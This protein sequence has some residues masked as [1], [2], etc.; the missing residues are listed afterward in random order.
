LKSKWKKNLRHFNKTHSGQ[1]M[2]KAQF[3]IPF[4]KSWREAICP[5][6]IIAGWRKS[7]LWPVNKNRISKDVFAPAELF[8]KC[9][10]SNVL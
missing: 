1:K 6:N 4:A 2:N 10:K 8:C 3:F 9:P 5:G 7:G